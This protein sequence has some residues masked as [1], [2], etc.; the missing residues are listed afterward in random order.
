MLICKNVIGGY[1]LATKK[2]KAAK[3]DKIEKENGGKTNA[4]VQEVKATD[5]K[6]NK[7]GKGK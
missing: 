7:K 1:N 2:Q 4:P 6:V 3:R 5:N